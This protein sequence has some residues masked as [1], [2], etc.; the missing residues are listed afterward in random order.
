MGQTCHFLC[1]K[2][3]HVHKVQILMRGFTA[4]VSHSNFLWAALTSCRTSSILSMDSCARTYDWRRSRS[5]PWASSGVVQSASLTRSSDTPIGSGGGREG[6]VMGS[7]L[8]V[9]HSPAHVV[10]GPCA[11]H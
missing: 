5:S 9:T 1:R 2:T 8:C 11:L 10:P 7:L 3:S 4:T 6:M